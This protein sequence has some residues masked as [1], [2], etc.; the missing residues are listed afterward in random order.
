[1]TLELD[2]HSS[3][4][5]QDFVDLALAKTETP[6]VLFSL[7]W[8]SYCRAIKQLL[9]SLAIKYYEYE[10]DRGDFLEPNLQQQV[11]SRL[12][13]LTRSGTLPQLFIGRDPL[14]GYTE[15][16]SAAKN[17]RLKE[18]LDKHGVGYADVSEN[19]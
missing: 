10:L 19:N 18:A 12:M 3:K 7:S 14:G 17:G 15:T 16:V 2:S 13:Q 11:R 8:C 4:P 1:M 5:Q 6:V 9:N